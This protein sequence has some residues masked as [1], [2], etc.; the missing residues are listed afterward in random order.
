MPDAP[1]R[2]KPGR[3]RRAPPSLSVSAW[4][5]TSTYDRLAQLALKRGESVSELTRSIL[6]R[7]TAPRQTEPPR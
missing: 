2:R 1:E 6:E 3:P 5:R 7:A 4:V